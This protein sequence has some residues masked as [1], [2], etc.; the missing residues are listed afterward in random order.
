MF[1]KI[2]LLPAVE[3]TDSDIHL[4]AAFDP[5][6]IP[7]ATESDS[8]TAWALWEH[9]LSGQSV[10]PENDFM[11]TIPAELPAYLFTQPLNR[12]L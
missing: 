5:I 9:S 1:N 11:K 6:P 2:K 10:A 12:P 8:D 7:E 3:P 4:Y